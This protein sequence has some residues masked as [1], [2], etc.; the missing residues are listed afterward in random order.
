MRQ[1]ERPV[2]NQ[3]WSFWAVTAVV[4]GISAFSILVIVIGLPGSYIE[5]SETCSNGNLCVQTTQSGTYLSSTPVAVIPLLLGVVVALGV[6]RQR[7]A[8]SWAGM[9]GLL[10]FTFVSMFSLGLLYLPFTIVLFVILAA[11]VNR[12]PGQKVPPSLTPESG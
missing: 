2:L 6:F 9:I 10:V 4:A 11:R 8:V 12:A 7:T 1:R 3:H 5:V